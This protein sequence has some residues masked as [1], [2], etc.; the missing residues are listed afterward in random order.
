MLLILPLLFVGGNLRYRHLCSQ[1]SVSSWSLDLRL[2]PLL[3]CK[4][5][6]ASQLHSFTPKK[7]EN[8]VR[9][10]PRWPLVKRLRS[11]SR[12]CWQHF[13][14]HF[15]FRYAYFSLRGF[16]LRTPS[17]HTYQTSFHWPK[18]VSWTAFNVREP[19]DQQ[20]LYLATLG[21]RNSNLYWRAHY[22][23]N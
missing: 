2:L 22:Y 7:F 10:S 14:L 12:S 8:S 11:V 19:E 15:D 21:N 6:T 23:W 4:I 9:G 17:P 13:G 3:Y 1:R 16:P 20:A 5:F 18:H